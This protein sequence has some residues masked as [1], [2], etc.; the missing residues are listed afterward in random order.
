MLT[1]YKD[2]KSLFECKVKVENANL[3]NAKARLVLSG[4]QMDYVFK[5]N[6]DAMGNFSAEIPPLYSIDKK[7]GTAVLEV[8]VDGGYFEPFKTE[9]NLVS[10]EVTVENVTVTDSVKSVKVEAA[11]VVKEKRIVESQEK[12][13]KI[14]SKVFKSNSSLGDIK[15][16]KHIIETIGNLEEKHKN[17]L[18][19]YVQYKY[20]P[21]NKSL[22]WAKTVFKN[23][24]SNISKLVMYKLDNV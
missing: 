16:A 20:N 4:V 19:E 12:T 6:L 21:S 22:K 23:P 3:S 1:L 15:T 24:N 5:G 9:Y 7:R 11:E 10:K 13:N 14:E 18:K 8:V 17:A 2:R